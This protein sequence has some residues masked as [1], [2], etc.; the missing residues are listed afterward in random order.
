MMQQKNNNMTASIQIKRSEFLEELIQKMSL[1]EDIDY[2]ILRS[3]VH[4]CAIDQYGSRYIQQTLDLT[5]EE[6]SQM[7]DPYMLMSY[8]TMSPELLASQPFKDL[9]FQE[10]LPHC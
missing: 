2:H 9:V 10:T 3:H 4:E 1:K 5:K 8:D 6:D 7:T